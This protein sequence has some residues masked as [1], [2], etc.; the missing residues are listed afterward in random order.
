MDT[1][2]LRYFR[3]VAES[4]NFT[5][6]AASLYMSQTTLSYQISSLEKE[7]GVK[8]FKR[9][10][11][12]VTLTPAGEKL[13]EYTPR[14]LAL[15]N[16]AIDA[17][18][19]AGRGFNNVL[20]VGFL[21]A[22][23]QRF[24]PRLIGDFNSQYPDVDV[25]LTQGSPRKLMDK[26]I[27]RQLDFVFTI[28]KDNFEDVEGVTVEYFGKLPLSALMRSDNEL[29]SKQQL[30]RSELADQKLCFLNEDEGPD[31]SRHFVE[32]FAQLGIKPFI[33]T[34]STM[35]SVTMLIESKGYIT[36]APKCLTEKY[37]DTFV[38]VPMV[39]ENEFVYQAGAWRTEDM[40]PTLSQ[41][42]EVTREH[43]SKPEI[44]D[45]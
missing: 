6:A 1:N 31:L 14:I 20:K 45:L 17:S 32:S 21:G 35:Q 2:Q 10:H 28:F 11:S 42:L 26:L 12:G 38:A 23:E 16:E 27:N 29:A 4:L 15:T 9:G 13:L 3:A 8:L 18:V 25:V 24:L 43:L 44:W 41:F 30:N 36:I 7:M 19:N 5:R 37:G 39:G 22:H 40:S 34:T 33:D